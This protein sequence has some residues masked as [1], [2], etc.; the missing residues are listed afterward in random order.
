METE[1]KPRPATVDGVVVRKAIFTSTGLEGELLL[2]KRAKE[3]HL[4]EWALPGGYMDA[5]ETASEA[6]VREVLEETGVKVKPLK[7]IGV[8]SDP[9]R[10]PRQ[11]VSIA[12]LC[13]A[14]S[15]TAQGGDDAGEAKWW[16]LSRLP[17]L[18]FDHLKIV[19]SAV[20]V[21]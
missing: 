12:F 16:P 2:I 10:D 5:D 8:F 14:L 7:M 18:A 1:Y 15:G 20:G 21:A 17:P 4:G 13:E 9:K 3:P 6:V 19:A 11:T